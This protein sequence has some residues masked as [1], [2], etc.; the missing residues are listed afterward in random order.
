MEKLDLK[1]KL[2]NDYKSEETRVKGIARGTIASFLGIDTEDVSVGGAS[3][4]D[5]GIR[6]YLESGGFHFIYNHPNKKIEFS[7]DGNL[8]DV[9]T[10]SDI[11]RIIS[12]KENKNR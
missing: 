5:K 6:V 8:Y 1:E 4:N 11:G 7:L 3:P 2:I 9:E 10:R 12:F